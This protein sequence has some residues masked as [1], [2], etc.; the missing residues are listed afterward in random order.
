MLSG[1]MGSLD[2]FSPGDVDTSV[3]TSSVRPAGTES[4]S[5]EATIRNAVSSADL[6]RAAGNPV[7]W[8]NSTSGS[9]GVIDA[10]TESKDD[11]GRLCR[12]FL[13]TRHSYQGIAYF[14]GKTCVGKTGEW[15]LLNLTRQ[16]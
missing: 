7:P 16:G 10:I 6:D 8:A 2:L 9:A 5:D 15:L 13:T 3:K 12:D 4:A 1:C 14:R 11:T